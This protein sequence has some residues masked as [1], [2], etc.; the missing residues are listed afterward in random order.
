MHAHTRVSVCNTLLIGKK[1]RKE[2]MPGCR[3]AVASG[4]SDVSSSIVNRL[5]RRETKNHYGSNGGQRKLL[6]H[7]T[8][9]QT[10]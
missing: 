4:H 7:S 5:Q 8:E 10:L 3:Q 2:R 9:E 6:H 1:E